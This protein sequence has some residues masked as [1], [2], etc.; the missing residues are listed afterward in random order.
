MTYVSFAAGFMVLHVA[1]YTIAGV[2]ALA[3]SGSLY[4][5]P[6]RLLDFLRDAGD[7]VE[8]KRLQKWAIPAQLVRGVVLSLVLLPILEPLQGI[9]FWSQF[10]FVFGLMFVISDLAS[11]APFPGNIEGLIY[12]RERYLRAGAYWRLHFESLLY[13]SV[14]ATSVSLLLL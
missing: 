2:L 14:L 7:P 10:A 13:S 11:S 9:G 3:I 5:G 12:L 6:D 4:R 1:C 8:G